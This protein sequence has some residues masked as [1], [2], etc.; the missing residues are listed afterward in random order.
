[1]GS[2]PRH[3][4][5]PHVATRPAEPN[6]LT[7]PTA[8]P[9][10][11]PPAPPPDSIATLQV[12]APSTPLPV[13]PQPLPPTTP[14]DDRPLIK[15]L[16]AE[17]AEQLDALRELASVHP[18][19][20]ASRHDDLWLLRFLM[21][22]NYEAARAAKVA[23]QVLAWRRDHR[24]DEVARTVSTTA[25]VGWPHFAIVQQH[26]TQYIYHPD[27]AGSAFMIMRASEPRRLL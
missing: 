2:R 13:N 11:P 8:V 5:P 6:S 10:A 27:P 15:E 18:H 1:M 7:S 12:K 4:A 17:R 19:Y 3:R 23:R 21:S 16:L 9:L 24:M 14:Q 22:H 26:L 25:Q 20:D